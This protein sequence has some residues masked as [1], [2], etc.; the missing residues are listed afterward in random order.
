MK[1]CLVWREC[2]SKGT[3]LL[4]QKALSRHLLTTCPSRCYCLFICICFHPSNG[5]TCKERLPKPPQF[6]KLKMYQPHSENLTGLEVIWWGRGKQGPLLLNRSC[7]EQ[8]PKKA[9]IYL[10]WGI[11]KIAELHPKMTVIQRP[12]AATLL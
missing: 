10:G 12:T 9:C 7:T 8:T 11:W 6:I 3:T 4:P 1:V 2:L 5:G